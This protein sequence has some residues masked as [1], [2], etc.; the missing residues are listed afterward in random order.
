MSFEKRS[1]SPLHM[2]AM[3]SLESASLNRISVFWIVVVAVLCGP[4][5]KY[6]TGDRCWFIDVGVVLCERLI[7][8]LYASLLAVEEYTTIPEATYSA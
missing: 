1:L 2:K 5:C 7:L 3:E 8:V 6:N 4:T